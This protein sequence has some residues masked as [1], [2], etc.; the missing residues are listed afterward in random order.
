MSMKM[1]RFWLNYCKTHVVV[2][3]KFTLTTD[4]LDA[5]AQFQL[6]PCKSNQQLFRYPIN[7]NHQ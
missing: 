1:L 5:I 4:I 2:T 7:N 3:E 6:E